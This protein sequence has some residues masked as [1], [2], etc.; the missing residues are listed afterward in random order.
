MDAIIASS[1]G[2]HTSDNFRFSASVAM[3]SMLLRE[4]AFTGNT[5]AAAIIELANSAK[6]QDVHGYRDEFVRLVETFDLVAIAE[7]GSEPSMD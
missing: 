7:V 6:G 5:S 2:R 1:P 3:F 4:S